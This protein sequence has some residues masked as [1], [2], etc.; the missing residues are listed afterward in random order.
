M[1]VTAGRDSFSLGGYE[2]TPLA[3]LLPVSLE[4]ASADQRRAMYGLLATAQYSI[5]EA[6]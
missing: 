6:V 5:S 1:V 4:F 3:E 2:D